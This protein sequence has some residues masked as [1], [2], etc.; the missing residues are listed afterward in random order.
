MLI[1]LSSLATLGLFPL[2]L[3][4]LLPGGSR[5]TLSL[6]LAV[7]LARKAVEW[8]HT[9]RSIKQ[10]RTEAAFVGQRLSE[11]KLTGCLE[12][13]DNLWSGSLTLGLLREVGGRPFPGLLLLKEEQQRMH[14]LF[15]DAFLRLPTSYPVLDLV[16]WNAL[17]WSAMALAGTAPWTS[18]WV[19]ALAGIALVLEG[20]SLISRWQLRRRLTRLE[21]ALADWVLNSVTKMAMPLRH[22]VTYAHTVLYR[23][24]PWFATPKAP[25]A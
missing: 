4:H 18:G 6:F 15:R 25:S 19:A 9:E 20:V 7:Y 21:L 10:I 8:I 24:S 12:R 16:L 17:F 3:R 22:G 1:L 13:P 5:I 2:L 14:Q 11:T 23:S